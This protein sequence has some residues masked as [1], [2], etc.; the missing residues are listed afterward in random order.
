MS[1]EAT[2]DTNVIPTT[3][4]TSTGVVLGRLVLRH[5]RSEISAERATL[6][7]LTICDPA[8]ATDTTATTSTDEVPHDR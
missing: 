7:R 6:G 3:T 4:E 1:N 8:A 2:P 5:E